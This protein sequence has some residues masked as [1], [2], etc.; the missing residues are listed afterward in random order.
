M[1]RN[2]TLI[3][4]L[5]ILITTASVFASSGRPLDSRGAPILEQEGDAPP[6]DCGFLGIQCGFIPQIISTILDLIRGFFDFARSAIEAVLGLIRGIA[7]FLLNA[8]RNVVSLIISLF[9]PLIDLIRSVLKLIDEVF[10][11]I[12][13]LIDLIV[14]VFLL[15][16][17]WLLQA[18]NLAISFLL[19]YGSAAPTPIPGLPRCVTAPTEYELCGFYYITDWT[20]FAPATPGAI[21]VPLVTIILDIVIVFTFVRKIMNIVDSGEKTTDV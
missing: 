20:L 5:L 17:A 12:G 16:G 9:Q 8:V 19:S 13:I 2:R 7:E 6:T 1:Y 14:R 10:H 3:A 15:I 4:L 11:I 21:I 18:V